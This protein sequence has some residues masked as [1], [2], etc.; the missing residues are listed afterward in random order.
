MDSEVDVA[1]LS[2]D[3]VEGVSCSSPRTDRQ[4]ADTGRRARAP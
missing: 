3:E 1:E 4:P 2:S